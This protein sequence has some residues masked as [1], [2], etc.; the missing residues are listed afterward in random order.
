MQAAQNHVPRSSPTWDTRWRRRAVSLPILFGV[1]TLTFSASPL[2]LFATAA[3][4]LAARRRV[5]FSRSRTVLFALWLLAC[6]VFGVLAAGVLWVSHLVTG[7]LAKP[8]FV[9]ANAALQRVWTRAI[10][11]AAV[12]LFGMSVR[13]EGFEETEHAPF[14][15]F[16]RHVSTADTVIAAALIANPRKLLVRYVLKRELAWDPC[17]DI[18]GHR[19]PNVFVDRSGKTRDAE[20]E[21]VA[22]LA[23]DLDD[24]SA[25]LIYPEGTRFTPKK[26]AAAIAKLDGA[27]ESEL[28]AIAREYKNVLPPKLGGPLALLAN[29]PGV[30]VVFVEHTGFEDVTSLRQIWRGALA[31]RTLK[32]RLRRVAAADIP[33][34]RREAWLFEEWR[35]MDHWVEQERTGSR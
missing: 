14:L 10:F 22:N 5:A 8:S 29:A 26:H 6:E 17:L 28:S 21:R 19:L 35:A 18:V 31:G 2:L 24:R 34:A 15:L 32:V 3:L 7:S 27:G 33:H 1:A 4:D 16:V 20:L 25:V 9:E 13:L 23:K 30:D 11:G 12:R